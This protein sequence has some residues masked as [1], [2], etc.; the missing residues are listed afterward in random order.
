M[1]MIEL[2]IN[3]PGSTPLE[4]DLRSGRPEDSRPVIVVCHGFL[5]YKR[6]GFFPYLSEH[7]AAAGFHVL[8]LSFSRNGIDE[9]TGLITKPE[10]FAA[11][12]VS[13]EVAD[14]ENAGRFVISDSFP[15]P[16]QGPRL[17][18]L[19]HSRGGSACLLASFSCPA[20]RSIVTWSA[21]SKLDRYTDLRKQE[22]KRTGRLEFKE[23]RSP[24]PLW[25]DYAY[26]RDIDRNREK[27]D[28][29]SRAADLKIPHLIVHGERDAAVT[30]KEARRLVQLPRPGKVSLQIIKGCGHTFGI[31]HPMRGP[32]R[33]LEK[34]TSLTVAWFKG[35]LAAEGNNIVEEES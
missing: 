3:N 32:T 8:T 6:W 4:A 15:L 5:G 25:L 14:L 30:L 7:L 13:R 29:K 19:G 33:G 24:T 11:N 17:G 34:A 10:E 16:V 18:L 20:V 31:S 35:T 22:W 12:T 23:S 26:Y 9:H 27:F 1:E 28:L 21:A 2:K